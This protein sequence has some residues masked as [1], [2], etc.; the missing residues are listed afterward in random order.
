MPELNRRRFLQFAGAAGL[1]PI[2]P[3][4]P[5]SAAASSGTVISSQML[6]AS[7]YAKA[8]NAQ[9]AQG[10]A[11][12]MGISTEAA[13]GIY[14]KLVQNQ[15]LAANTLRGTLRPAPAQAQPVTEAVRPKSIKVN[16]EK[17]LGDAPEEAAE[18]VEP[19]PVADELRAL[20]I[21]V[22]HDLPGVGNLFKTRSRLANK[23]EMLVFITPKTIADKAVVR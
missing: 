14:A 21:D 2:M 4:L 13:Q 17:L 1:A 16:I 8:G 22:V 9:N 23:Q 20:G 5:A 19:A 18:P 6:W 10:I 7:L 3:A 12:A 11:S 15:L